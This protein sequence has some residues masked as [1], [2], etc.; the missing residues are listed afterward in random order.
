MWWPGPALTANFWYEAHNSPGATT[1]A[2]RWALAGGEV[3][4]ADDAET[5]VLIAN[6]S[7]TPGRARVTLLLRLRGRSTG[8][9]YD[10]PAEE[11]HQRAHRP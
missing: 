7:T 2:T 10:L 9:D 5:Y 8:R 11:P 4:G 3:G 1:T 6:T